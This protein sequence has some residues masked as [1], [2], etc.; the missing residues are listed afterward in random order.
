MIGLTASVGVGKSNKIPGAKNHIKATMSNL[1]A[2][3]L[4]TVKKNRLE[5]SEHV[6]VP[7]K[8]LCVYHFNFH[9]VTFG[10]LSDI[11]DYL[12]GL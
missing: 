2:V 1:D 4:V 6:V 7:D 12:P 3:E 5:L 11:L 8:G 9:F 10:N